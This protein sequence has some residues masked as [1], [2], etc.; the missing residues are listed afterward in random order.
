[1][2]A[3][4]HCP[5]EQVCRHIFKFALNMLASTPT[6]GYAM[7]NNDIATPF[8]YETVDLLEDFGLCGCLSVFII[9]PS[10]ISL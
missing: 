1:M 9:S 7:L 2:E 5:K 4:V 10:R 3:L 6:W 8:P